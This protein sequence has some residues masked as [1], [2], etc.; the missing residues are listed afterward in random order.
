MIEYS[1]TKKF[2]SYAC[3]AKKLFNLKDDSADCQ[4]L[5]FDF[6]FDLR[7]VL[8]FYRNNVT[9]RSLLNLHVKTPHVR[10]GFV[11]FYFVYF[12]YNKFALG[13]SKLRF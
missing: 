9:A 10:H 7:F 8:I 2:L 13:Y 3:E 5:T 6:D 4:A 1:S 11:S 12:G